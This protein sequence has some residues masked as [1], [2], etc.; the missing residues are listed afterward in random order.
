MSEWNTTAFESLLVDSK[1]GEFIKTPDMHGNM[2]IFS[3]TELL[4]QDG[5][6]SQASQTIPEGSICVS[7]IGTGGVVSI[8]TSECQT[9]QQI[10][11]VVLKQKSELEWA[12][13]VL[14]GLEETV[15][16]FGSTGTTMT[17]LSKGK[18]AAL[19]I[20]RPDKTLILRFHEIVKPMF[21]QIQSLIKQ[22]TTLIRSRDLL[23]PRLISGKL[24]V[25]N[26]DIQFPPGMAEELNDAPAVVH[27]G[28]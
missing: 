6:D 10:N 16:L 4:S 1:D 14:K 18:F 23:L 11:S 26:L 12:F 7:C 25:E 9:N 19:K 20:L 17:N 15:Q 13:F 5:L 21:D 28:G 3:T 2:F 24:S 27:A 8:T 22:R